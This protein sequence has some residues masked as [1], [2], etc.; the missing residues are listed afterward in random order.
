MEKYIMPSRIVIS[1]DVAGEEKLLIDKPLQANF[2]AKDCALIKKGGFVVLDFGKELNGGIA[3]SIQEND[4]GMKYGKVR[5]VFGESVMEALSTLG[6][7]NATNDHSIRDT[8]LDTTYWSTTRFGAT[9]FRFVKLEAVESDIAVKV[10]KAEPDIKDLEYKGSFESSDSLLNEIWKTG[11]YTVHLN[12]HEFVWDGIKRDRLVW[13]GDMHPEMSTIKAVFGYDDCVPNSLNFAKAE[14]SCDQWINWF[15]SYS[16]WWIIIHYDWY[17]QNGDLDYLKD[18]EDYIAGL[19][20]NAAAWV[21][22]EKK[23]PGEIFVDWSSNADKTA[24]LPGVYAVIYKAVTTAGEIF[25]ILGNGVMAAKCRQIAG[26]LRGMDIVVPNQKQ[27]AGLCVY[28][29]LAE[30]KK[31]NE[32]ILAKDPLEGLSTFIG[33]Y[34][35]KA[36]AMAGDMQGALD[37]IRGYWGAMLSLGATTFWEDFDISWVDNAG[38]IDEVVPE[39]KKD[40]HGDYGKFCYTQ[41]RHSLCHGW[42]SGPTAFL[43]QHVLGFTV[44]APGCKKLIIQPDLGDLEWAKGTYP[45]PYGVVSVEH[46]KVDGKVVTSYTAPAEVTVEVR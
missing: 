25:E 30:G 13:L 46:R 5:V 21:R 14:F 18:Q 44:A 41:F 22:N 33:Y 3:M 31:V 4:G 45:T 6:E 36:R 15:P 16:M 8:V 11:A 1:K 43:S 23:N 20:E 35:L 39:G 19:V 9:G 7:K 10:V 40:V 27:I 26:E 24:A 28:S 29:G 37:V 34:V 42:A 38:R 2:S 12:M 17:M 32:K